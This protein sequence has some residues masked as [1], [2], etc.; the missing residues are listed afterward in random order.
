MEVSGAALPKLC[1]R[2]APVCLGLWCEMA[3]T[4]HVNPVSPASLPAKLV[5]DQLRIWIYRLREGE[6]KCNSECQ[7]VF[8]VTSDQ[9]YSKFV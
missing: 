7:T 8:P 2:T 9:A 3:F 4:P 6:M 5:G 1:P